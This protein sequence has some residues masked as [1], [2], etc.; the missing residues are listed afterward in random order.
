M[1]REESQTLANDLVDAEKQIKSLSKQ[2]GEAQ[3][4]LQALQKDNIRLEDEINDAQNTLQTKI[5]E[6]NDTKQEVEFLRRPKLDTSRNSNVFEIHGMERVSRGDTVR[7]RFSRGSTRI[8]DLSAFQSRRSD[9]QQNMFYMLQSLRGASNIFSSN[10]SLEIKEP[11][12]SE[13]D[14]QDNFFSRGTHRESAKW[15][16]QTVRSVDEHVE[17][18][19]SD[20]KKPFKMDIL[21]VYA[22]L[23]AAA[24]KTNYPDIDFPKDDLIRLG[25]NMPFW[26]LHPYYTHIFE[27]VKEKNNTKRRSTSSRTGGWLRWMRKR[28]QA[29][30]PEVVKKKLDAA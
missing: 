12:I 22:H 26:E 23:T 4:A 20:E 25:N 30:A 16:G 18:S 2:L 9:I 17:L 19:M 8:G 6:L 24:V 11:E 27:S 1:E 5:I 15:D 29:D 10:P 14:I 21:D 3:E 7:E 28:E 13:E